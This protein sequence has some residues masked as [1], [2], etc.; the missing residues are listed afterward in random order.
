MVKIILLVSQA[1]DVPLGC[2]CPA[3]LFA[4]DGRGN[5]RSEGS[6][7]RVS[8]PVALP[9][10]VDLWHVWGGLPMTRSN[11]WQ[12][13]AQ[14]KGCTWQTQRAA[15]KRWGNVKTVW[16]SQNTLPYLAIAC[17]QMSAAL[18]HEVLFLWL[19]SRLLWIKKLW[20]SLSRMLRHRLRL[21]NQVYF[22]GEMPSQSCV[23]VAFLWAGERGK[24]CN[25]SG[26]RGTRSES[27]QMLPGNHPEAF[28]RCCVRDTI[29][30]VVPLAR[31]CSA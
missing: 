16:G 29:T 19:S 21:L 18:V 28:S 13:M 3:G 22:R 6:R 2:L 15:W 1:L 14:G 5:R 7:C 20:G 27:Y 9:F 8:A 23:S 17:R 31:W 26:W 10:S 30:G 11:P 4:L 25:G 12:A 24:W